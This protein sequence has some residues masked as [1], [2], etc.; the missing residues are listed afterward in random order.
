MSMVHAPLPATKAESTSASVAGGRPPQARALADH[1][2]PLAPPRARRS[3]ILA[4]LMLWP[5]VRV[6]IF[7]LQ[8]YGLREIDTGETNWI[9]FANY[10][11]ALTNPTLWTVVLPEH[12]R[13]RRR[14]R[15]RHRRRRHAR[16]AA[17]GERSAPSGAPSSRSCIMVAW[18]M[19]AVTGTY[20]W[21][22]IFDADRGIF[23][24][25]LHGPRAHGRARSTGSR[26]SGRSTRSCCST[27]STTASRSSRSPCSP[28]CSASPRR[29]SKPRRS[30]APTPGRRFWKIIFPIAQAGVLGRDHPVDDL[31][32][33]GLRAGLPDAGRRRRQPLGA[34]PRRL[35][36]RRVLRPEPL[37]L[38]LGDRRAAH[39]RA[40]RHHDRVHPRPS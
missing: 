15:V 19:P 8:D 3:L 33:Q 29:C 32:L 30:T 11:E 16:R 39:A 36:V 1:G 18:A 4:V 13:L 35:V 17:A 20:V 40:A 34:E 23:N 25:S 22:W 27:W 14:R 37:R 38:R 24:Q 10:V 5:L 28:V 6:V 21:I 31:G 26:T 2:P 7:S 12:R 9:G